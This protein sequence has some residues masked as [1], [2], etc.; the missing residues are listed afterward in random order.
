MRTA[1]AVVSLLLMV[2]RG[3]AA[4][5][6]YPGLQT[7][8]PIRIVA[9]LGVNTLNAQRFVAYG[10]CEHEGVRE[11]TT[12]LAHSK[13]EELW[14]YLPRGQPSDSCQWHEIGRNEHSGTD[15]AYVDVDWAYLETLM[16]ENSSVYLY[17]FHP[18]TFFGYAIASPSD[19]REE[20]F[21]GA[22]VADL[23]FSMPSPADI[24][25]MMEI[26]SR[27]HQ[28]HPRGGD[29]RNSVV[30][31]YGI[32]DY[33][34]TEAGRTKYESDKDARTQGL[35]IK[36]VAASALGDESIE[37]I[38]DQNSSDIALSMKELVEVLNTQYLRL[39]F[40]PLEEN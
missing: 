14:A 18:L 24:H 38:I 29:I 32:V 26:T 8:R 17:H 22:I 35:Y 11:I 39:V 10:K 6:A 34:L 9:R 33:A 1:V 15:N 19:K 28:Y 31:P 37:A 12:L 2:L 21:E 7:D 20:S 36:Y 27:F 4:A 3:V 30:T 23:R 13:V 25:F 16:A 5:G 40:S